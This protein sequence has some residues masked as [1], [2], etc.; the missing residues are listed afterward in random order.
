MRDRSSARSPATLTRWCVSVACRRMSISWCPTG[1]LIARARNAGSTWSPSYIP[2]TRIALRHCRPCAPP[3]PWP[4][5]PPVVGLLAEWVLG[6][7]MSVQHR[8]FRRPFNLP[9]LARVRARP[10][11]AFRNWE[12][13]QVLPQVPPPQYREHLWPQPQPRPRPRQPQRRW[14]KP[15]TNAPTAR[16]TRTAT[17]KRRRRPNGLATRRRIQ[18]PVVQRQRHPLHHLASL[19]SPLPPK[20]SGKG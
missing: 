8:L 4:T 16:T 5:A 13:A 3:R 18:T 17:S 20:P 12:G 10:L 15:K 11:R 2:W 9:A 7:A 1:F 14:P 6:L 19:M